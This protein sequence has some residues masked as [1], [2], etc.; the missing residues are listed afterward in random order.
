M[1][2]NIKRVLNYI[3]KYIPIVILSMAMES[4]KY[5]RSSESICLLS[6]SL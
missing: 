3:K 1:N 4:S 2:S 6:L 5:S